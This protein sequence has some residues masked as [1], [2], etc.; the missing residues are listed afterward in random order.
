ME[1]TEE[2]IRNRAYQIW[3]REGQPHGRNL[4]HWLQ[5][6]WEL[7]NEAAAKNGSAE[8]GKAADASEKPK[9][10]RRTTKAKAAPAATADAAPAKTTKAKSTTTTKAPAKPRSTTK[11]A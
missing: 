7:M 11:K 5:A 1:I 8:A 6:H 3:E 10:T 4:E 2:Q 9:T